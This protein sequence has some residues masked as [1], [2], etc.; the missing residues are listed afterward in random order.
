MASAPSP[1]H[2]LGAATDPDVHGAARLPRWYQ[3]AQAL[4]LAVLTRSPEDGDRLPTESAMASHYGVS[5]ATVRQALAVLEEEGL[6]SRHRRRGTFITRYVRRARRLRVAGSLDTVVAQQAAGDVQVLSHEEVATPPSLAEHFPGLDRVVAIQRV[7]REDG[8]AVSYAENYLRP[9]IGRRVDPDE[10]RRGSVTQV[11]RD[12]LSIDVSRVEETAEAHLA[13]PEIAR[14][15]GV[16]LLSPILYCTGITIDGA[17]TVVDVAHLWYR[18][19]R[20][21]FSV[22][23]DVA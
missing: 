15:L 21:T 11:L 17:G 18:G 10:L 19:D 4:R 12:R 6:I 9:E 14:I 2:L 8:A 7:R 22:S 13:T 20:F 1:E 3:V 23:I 5:V 16:E